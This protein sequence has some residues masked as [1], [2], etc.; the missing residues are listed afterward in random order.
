MTRGPPRSWGSQRMK[1]ASLK[2]T[3]QLAILAAV[4]LVVAAASPIAGSGVLTD[5]DGYTLYTFDYDEHDKRNCNLEC[6]NVWKP[7]RAT[8][9]DRPSGRLSIVARAN[10]DR[11]WALDGRPLY[12][13]SGDAAPGDLSGEQLGWAWHAIHA[14]PRRSLLDPPP[15]ASN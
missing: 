11:Q 8:A 7:L 2:H 13:F 1:R 12:R 4:P 3:I 9:S 14:N 6:L 15:H 10:G 5:P